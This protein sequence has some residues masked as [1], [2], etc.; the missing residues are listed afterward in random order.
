M[1]RSLLRTWWWVPLVLLLGI[2]LKAW[3]VAGVVQ[4]RAQTL[5][6]EAADIPRERVQGVDGIEAP[7]RPQTRPSELGVGRRQGFERRLR[8]RSMSNHGDGSR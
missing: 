8:R 6:A 1:A 3:I 7:R 5:A 2:L 4:G